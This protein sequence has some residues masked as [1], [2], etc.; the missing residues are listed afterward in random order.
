VITTTKLPVRCIGL[1]TYFRAKSSN[2]NDTGGGFLLFETHSTVAFSIPFN[3]Q[4]LE[5]RRILLSLHN[6]VFT[7]SKNEMRRRNSCCALAQWHCNTNTV[8]QQ[9]KVKIFS[10][11]LKCHF[12]M[13]PSTLRITPVQQ[14]ADVICL[15][16]S[17]GQ[18]RASSPTLAD[19][20]FSNT[21]K[22]CV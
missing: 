20:S 21:F 2:F 15:L 13:R 18:R 22:V 5:Q 4:T 10:A 19:S 17:F 6:D 16:T 12:V 9:E 3:Q 14:V 11:I 7:E 8:V 1:Q